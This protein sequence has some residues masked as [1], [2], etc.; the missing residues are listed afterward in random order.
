M[1]EVEDVSIR[2]HG[3]AYLPIVSGNFWFVT[4][5]T[6]LRFGTN[7]GNLAGRSANRNSATSLI[8]SFVPADPK[9]ATSVMAP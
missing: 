9:F 2:I 6:M 5:Y 4:I 7:D 3:H 1:F 8:E